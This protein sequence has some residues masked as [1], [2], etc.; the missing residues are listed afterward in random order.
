MSWTSRPGPSQKTSSHSLLHYIGGAG[1]QVF[2][3]RTITKLC[4]L[5]LSVD[6]YV[7]AKG[8]LKCERDQRFGHKH[9]NYGNGPR[10]VVCALP[11]LRWLF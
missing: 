3:V 9:R 6:T 1:T 2:K 11:N 10:C 5:R 8:S 7:A 4:G